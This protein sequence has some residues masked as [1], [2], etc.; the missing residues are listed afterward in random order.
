MVGGSKSAVN[1]EN[2]GTPKTIDQMRAYRYAINIAN[3]EQKRPE[4]VFKFKD[5]L[6]DALRYALMAWP[7]LPA[8]K[9]ELMS[10]TQQRRWDAFDDTTRFHIEQMR[11]YEKR[12]TQKDLE[13]EE[14][15]Y[16]L[17]SFFGSDTSQ[18]MF[19]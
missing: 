12:E 7:E 16:P 9:V 10:P 1:V 13:P 4:K 19:D 14:D 8:P 2:R 5:E 15:N 11:D 3:D 6:P 17:G 18:G